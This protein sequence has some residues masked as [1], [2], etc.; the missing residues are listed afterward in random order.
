MSPPGNLVCLKNRLNNAKVKKKYTAEPVLKIHAWAAS[1][2][3]HHGNILE[4]NWAATSYKCYCL[5]L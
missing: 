5:A 3:Q 1:N 2:D 4:D